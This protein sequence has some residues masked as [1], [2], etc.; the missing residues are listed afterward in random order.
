M[1]A[2]ARVIDRQQTFQPG[3]RVTRYNRPGLW[4]VLW[5]SG[6]GRDGLMF[7]IRPVDGTLD[8]ADGVY[9]YELDPAPDGAR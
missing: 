8:D 2:P 4:T 5:Q 9:A 6:R 7:C 1:A 3:Y